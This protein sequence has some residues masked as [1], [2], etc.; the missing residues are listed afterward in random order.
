MA[1]P[2]VKQFDWSVAELPPSPLSESEETETSPLLSQ[3]TRDSDTKER[4]SSSSF[5]F[6]GV[7]NIWIKIDIGKCPEDIATQPSVFDDPK[8]A[9]Y[10]QPSPQY[11]NLHRFDPAE[12]WTWSEELP[13]IRTLDYRVTLWACIAF[14]ALDLPRT[15]VSQANTDNFLSDLGLSTNDFNLRNSLFRVGFLFAELPSQLISKRLGP[16]VWIP[17]QVSLTSGRPTID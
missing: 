8:L 9:P 13:L 5:S 14:F 17:T 4:I 3:S 2:D 12:R 10:F 11:E 16:D 15:N 6:S 1:N 7:T